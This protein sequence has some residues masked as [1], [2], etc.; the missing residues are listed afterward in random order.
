MCNDKLVALV[1][2]L[3]AIELWDRAGE[4][5]KPAPEGEIEARR[6]RRLEI[7]HE[8]DAMLQLQLEALRY[9]CR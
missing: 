9:L 1:A 8:I 6:L 3:R 5:L 2:E 7:I 4:K